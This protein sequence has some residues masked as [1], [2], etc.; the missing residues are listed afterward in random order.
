MPIQTAFSPERRVW[1]LPLSSLVES[2]LSHEEAPEEAPSSTVGTRITAE[3]LDWLSGPSIR[4]MILSS[5]SHD[6]GSIPTESPLQPP[7]ATEPVADDENDSISP[8]TRRLDKTL[9]ESYDEDENENGSSD[10]FK[11]DDLLPTGTLICIL[12]TAF[13]Y[14]C[15]M[16]TLFLITLP[17]E[18]A[19]INSLHPNIPKAVALGNFVA[20]AGLTQLVSPLVGRLSDTYRP[21]PVIQL[22]SIRLPHRPS[23]NSVALP[24]DNRRDA[25]ARLK[26]ELLSNGLVDIGSSN[27]AAVFTTVSRK[28]DSS[29]ESDEMSSGAIPTTGSRKVDSAID[30]DD[31]AT[32]LC[33]LDPSDYYYDIGQRLPYHVVGSV[34]TVIGLVGQIFSSYYNFWIRYS[35]AF[36]I[37]M[38]GLNVMYAMMIAL[39]PD[40]VPTAQV[41]SANGILALLLVVGSLTGFGL[42][43]SVLSDHIQNM[44]ALYACMIVLSSI[45]TGTHAH[46]AD[47][48]VSRPR[49][50]WIQTSLRRHPRSP[51]AKA[52]AP[53]LPQRL[54][55]RARQLVVTPTVILRSI[56]VDP[57][58]RLD[59]TS[60]S[61][62]YTIDIDRHHDFFIVTVSRFF[63]YCGM[64]VQTFF[65]YYVHDIIGIHNSP[66]AVVSYL[67]VMG[68]ISGAIT[69]YP[70]GVISDY[71]LQGRR[72]PFIY[73]ACIVLS[74]S[75]AALLFAHSIQHMM[76][77]AT[78]L[79]AANGMYLTMET[80][81]AVDSLPKDL[82]ED[83]SNGS[84]QLLGIWG[85]AAFL[86]SA[87]GPMIG[88]PLLYWLGT[89]ASNNSAVTAPVATS[90]LHYR[91]SLPEEEQQD[92][93][94]RGYAAVIIL[95]S[96][97]FL[98]SALSLRMLRDH[99]E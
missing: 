64:S 15:I 59:W 70:V 35:F 7:T 85:V 38:I 54:R 8:R 74:G 86:G 32:L 83:D 81:L 77:I 99:R 43:H 51:F 30:S 72:L 12:S 69:C 67:A 80:S 98:C 94:L 16:T 40:Q 49:Y 68:Q 10:S 61:Q 62:S 9:N 13:A 2:S 93:T 17:I 26:D 75:T 45:L 73:L 39:I 24:G 96:I 66:E 50:Q 95:S 58:Q 92:Y 44:Y 63:Y 88:G 60:I 84:A 97:Y 18:C 46:D 78:V 55:R 47:V 33:Y 34:C 1:S 31:E 3:S 11:K 5:R 14:G 71:Y 4:D 29:I 89:S 28:F 91:P 23:S 90:T 27:K 37:Q 57:V 19:R 76:T 65:L 20:I 41:G 6:Y 52:Q 42:Y 36:F 48:R 22:E 82:E 25:A 87:I 21:P 53:S 56:L 79:G